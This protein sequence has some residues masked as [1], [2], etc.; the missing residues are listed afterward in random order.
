M[1]VNLADTEWTYEKIDLEYLIYNDYRLR[2][3][4]LEDIE[5]YKC[6]K[7]SSTGISLLAIP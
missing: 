6:F 7:Y 1:S 5:V 4:D 3:K 2:E